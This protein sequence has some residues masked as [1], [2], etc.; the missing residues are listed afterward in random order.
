MFAI[1]KSRLAALLC[2]IAILLTACG[3]S[4]A[5]LTPTV[6][7]NAIRTEAVAT[8]A[9]SL[10]QTASA[11]PTATI[12]VTPA[13]TMTLPVL[14]TPLSTLPAAG[15]GT[16]VGG[17]TLC[18]R[19]VYVADVTVPDNTQ[20]TPGQ[21]FTKTWRVQ[22]T[23]TCA[24]TAGFKFSL[25]GGDPMGA[26]TVTLT[27]SVA[28]GATYEISVPMVAPT[29]KT[30]TVQGTWRMADAQGAFFGDSL[31]VVIVVAGTGPTSTGAVGPTNTTGAPAATGTPTVT[32]TPTTSGTP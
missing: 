25:I 30:G 22:N 32:V 9:F 19:L 16:A 1:R 7:P 18:T 6:N 5:E 23:G 12:T 2:V 3:P 27:Q 29:G 17:V 28:P 14:S 24:W 31:T 8:F 4:A 20:M 15:T 26:Q 10:T 13:P 21:S 11:R